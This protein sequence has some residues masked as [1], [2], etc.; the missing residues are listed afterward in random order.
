MRE[1]YIFRLELALENDFY[2]SFFVKDGF[3]GETAHLESQHYN[4]YELCVGSCNK[5]INH[6][7]KKIEKETK[8]KLAVGWETN[9][10]RSN[11]P[12]VLN[13]EW[14]EPEII[15]IFLVPKKQNDDTIILLTATISSYEVEPEVEFYLN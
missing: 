7:K 6:I 14:E 3:Y 5:I 12:K 11:K 1:Y 13:T 4:D 9:P 10:I 15:K 8:V 2:N